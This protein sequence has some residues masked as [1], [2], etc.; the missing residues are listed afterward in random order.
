MFDAVPFFDHVDVPEP[1]HPIALA[2]QP[3]CAALVVGSA[4]RMLS[5]VQLQH[6]TTLQASKIDNVSSDRRLAAELVTTELTFAQPIPCEPLYLGHVLPEFT[7]AV[8]VDSHFLPP[9]LTLPRKGGGDKKGLAHNGGGDK[10]SRL[11]S[12]EGR[13]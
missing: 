4:H 13:R 8:A 5:T 11:P 9:T 1:H 12:G 10:I 6:Q 2:F 7:D 3:V